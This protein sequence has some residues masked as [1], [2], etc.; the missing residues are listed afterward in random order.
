MVGKTGTEG[1]GFSVEAAVEYALSRSTS[2]RIFAA[3]ILGW[4]EPDLE[5]FVQ[6]MVLRVADQFEKHPGKTDSYYNVVARNCLKG[7]LTRGRKWTG[8][9][10]IQGKELDPY[11]RRLTDSIT[12]LEDCPQESDSYQVIEWRSLRPDILDAMECLPWHEQ[13]AVWGKVIA[14]Y[15]S[16]EVAE[17]I[18]SSKE[19]V[20]SAW[21]RA[22]ATLRD[23]LSHLQM[24]IAS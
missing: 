1:Y 5:D 23:R 19:A 24:W 12:H 7:L 21:Y 11:R 10:G 15:T 22:R 9:V 4:S 13:A 17:M 6:E 18:G 16:R 2:Y 3:Q 14:G 20:D 8:M